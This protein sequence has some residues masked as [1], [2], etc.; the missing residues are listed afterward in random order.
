MLLNIILNKS[1]YSFDILFICDLQNLF[2]KMSQS[3]QKYL[4]KSK[5]TK[6]KFNSSTE[7]EMSMQ[8]SWA[9]VKTKI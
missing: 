5:N 3:P 7:Y 6:E 1:C 9:D 8:K 2:Y 4:T